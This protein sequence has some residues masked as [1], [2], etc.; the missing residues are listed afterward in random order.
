[1]DNNAVTGKSPRFCASEDSY[2]LVEDLWGGTKTMRLAGERYL[3]R[4]KS[5]IEDDDKF[6]MRLDLS[7]LTNYFRKTITRHGG[8]IFSRDIQLDGYADEIV[9]WCDNVDLQGQNLT[10]FA[11]KLFLD[12]YQYGVSYVFT[13]YTRKEELPEGRERTAKDDLVENVRPHLVHIPFRNMLDVRTRI[14]NNIVVP[15]VVRFKEIVVEYPNIFEEKEVEQIRVLTPGAWEVWR[16][17]ETTKEWGLHSKGV[18]SLNEIPVTPLY[19]NRTGFFLGEPPLRDLAEKNVEHWRISS[20]ISLN[21]FYALSPMLF[22]KGVKPNYNEK[23]GEVDPV[24]FGPNTTM[25][26]ESENAD[27]K[28]VEPQGTMAKQAREDIQLL[29][30]EMTLLGLE[31]LIK[32]QRTA[33]EANA[34]T[35]ESHN[36]LK[37]YA[38][39]IK[40]TLEQALLFMNGYD[41]SLDREQGSVQVNTKFNI[42]TGSIEELKVL[43][44]MHKDA[45][46]VVTRKRLFAEAQRMGILDQDADIEEDNKEEEKFV[47]SL[48]DFQEPT[49]I[50]NNMAVSDKSIE[51]Q[52]DTGETNQ[53]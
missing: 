14:Q 52:A 51:G 34:E 50:V 41:Q 8:M 40:D 32:F 46:T 43:V 36:Q 35:N 24:Y 48:P 11:L 2:Q 30:D 26:Q 28:W 7:T 5:E 47:Q 12:A 23:T 33:T 49:V 3:P 27:I 22:G 9:K 39:S 31:Q 17:D 44:Q 15:S 13:D 21:R 25:F 42:S 10:Q 53:E 6:D 18:T 38:M 19:I 29:Q 45:P 20:G 1:M 16:M 4:S 37:A